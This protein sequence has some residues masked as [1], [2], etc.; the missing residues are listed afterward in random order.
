M[1]LEPPASALMWVGACQY[2]QEM[3]ETDSSPLSDREAGA[4]RTWYDA[5][6]HD[7][8]SKGD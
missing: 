3:T 5:I 1:A 2:R 4:I 7:R 8:G 6:L